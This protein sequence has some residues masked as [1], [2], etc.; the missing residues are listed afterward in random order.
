MEKNE[1]FQSKPINI[2]VN[3]S[4]GSCGGCNNCDNNPDIIV[5]VYSPWRMY[6]LFS[7]IYP[8]NYYLPY[9]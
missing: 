2:N 6:Y 5:P 9:Y 4:N 8:Y 1:T 7:T 3:C